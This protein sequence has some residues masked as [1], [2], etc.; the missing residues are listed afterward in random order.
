MPYLPI[1]PAH[2]GS[3]YEAVVRVNS[4]SDK[5][6]VAY[7]METEHGLSLPLRLQIQFLKTIQ[8]VVEDTGTE[9]TPVAM[10]DEFQAIYLPAEPRLQLRSHELVTRDDDRTHHHRAGR[11]RR[12]TG[13]GAG[14]GQRPNRG[15]RRRHP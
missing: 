10:W 3:S 1:D 7:I 14:P 15:V 2:A 12:R 6:G 8:A 13:H 9:I 11:R 5:G 4:Q